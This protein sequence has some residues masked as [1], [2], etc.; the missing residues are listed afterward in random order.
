MSRAAYILTCT[1]L[2]AAVMAA[3][4]WGLWQVVP[5]F[6]EW[7]RLKL[8][9]YGSSALLVSIIPI[10]YGIAYYFDWRHPSGSA[11]EP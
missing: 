6:V 8:G 5:G 3:V 11:R 9:L 10:G 4:A 1:V 2:Y 7:L